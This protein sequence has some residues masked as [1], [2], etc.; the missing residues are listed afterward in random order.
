[1]RE[2]KIIQGPLPSWI[3]QEW[4]KEAQEYTARRREIEKEV[5]R[6][7]GEPVNDDPVGFIDAL[8]KFPK[9]DCDDAIFDRHADNGASDVSC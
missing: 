3:D 8:L 7:M 2:F 5:R 6:K 4:L 1:M 9:I